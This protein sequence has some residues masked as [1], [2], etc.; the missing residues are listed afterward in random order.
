MRPYRAPSRGSAAGLRGACLGATLLLAACANNPPPPDWQMNA[1]GSLERATEAYLSG[2]DRIEVV[3]FARARTELARTGRADMVARAELMRCAAR[4][5]SLAFDDCPGFAALA[6][7]ASPALQAYAN[8]LAGKSTAQSIALLPPAQH[9]VAAG[10]DVAATLRRIDDPLSR[11]VAAGVLM[12]T[13][14]AE[15][16]LFALAAETASGQGW[17]RPLLAWLKVQLQ[18]AE[19]AGET[20]EATRLRRRI[21]LVTGELKP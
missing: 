13:G 4:V 2:S 19:A 7:D 11:L 1:K 17:R 15:P 12:R 5:A 21:E 16:A 9:D 10:K 6:Q 18:R 3:E 14:R 8:Y 20:V